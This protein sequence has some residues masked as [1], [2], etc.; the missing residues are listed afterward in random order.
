MSKVVPF[1]GAGA[2]GFQRVKS[3][4]SVREIS[5]QF[6]LGEHHI[7]RWARE[8]L[9]CAAAVPESAEQRYDHQALK[10]FRRVRELRNQGLSFRQIEAELRGQLNLF[11]EP[12]GRLI[13]LQRKLTP[14]EEALLLDERSDG[15]APEAYR[16]AIAAGDS[17]ADALCNLGILEFQAGNI[18]AAFDRFTK[19]LQQDPRHFE[20]HFN[21]ASL[22]F[23]QE[24]LRLARLHYELA[25]E[26]EP[27]FPDIFFN[28]GLV[29]ALNGDFRAAVDALEK[30]RSLASEEESAKVVELLISLQ[31]A[32]MMH[33]EGPRA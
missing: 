5:Q 31:K 23:D 2:H 25:A 11:P 13:R 32:L 4:Y 29:H 24:D 20:S 10:Q 15:R 1:P 6:G 21:L 19:S 8:G 9:I 27:N 26:I 17:I 30:A 3:T 22:Y 12:E 16:Q 7:R 14:F 33:P 18:A 28:L